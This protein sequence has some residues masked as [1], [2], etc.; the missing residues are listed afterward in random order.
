MLKDTYAGVMQQG[1]NLQSQ[2]LPQIQA[3]ARTLDAGNVLAMVRGA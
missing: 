2:Y 1:R 3:R